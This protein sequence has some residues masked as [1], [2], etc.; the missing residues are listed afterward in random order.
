MHAGPRTR[1]AAAGGARLDRL[2]A[3]FV[4]VTNM[5]TEARQF[6]GGFFFRAISSDGR[7]LGVGFNGVS[8]VPEPIL[9]GANL[10]PGDTIRGYLGWEIPL[11]AEIVSVQFKPTI[12]TDGNVSTGDKT[13]VIGY[14]AVATFHY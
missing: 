13:Y 5:G 1:R 10:A 7:D 14:P 4:V 3:A 8:A 11:G 2:V 9:P 6:G 12:A